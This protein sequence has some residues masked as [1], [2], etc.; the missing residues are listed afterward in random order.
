MA[1]YESSDG[2]CK[3]HPGRKA[4]DNRNVCLECYNEYQRD[5]R[6]EQRALKRKELQEAGLLKKNDLIVL[7]GKRIKKFWYSLYDLNNIIAKEVL[8]HSS[9]SF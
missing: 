6:R 5:K 3:N 7:S 2:Y 1:R 9:K 8:R 4:L